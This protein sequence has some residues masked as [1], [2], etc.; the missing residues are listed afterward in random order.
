MKYRTDFVTNSSSSS[1][2]A[3]AVTTI[4]GILA[5]CNCTDEAEK[6]NNFMQSSVM[7]EDGQKLVAGGD[8]LYLYAQLCTT[9]DKDETI[10]LAEPTASIQYGVSEGGQWV[11]VSAMQIVGD[12]AAVEVSGITPDQDIGAAP[13]KIVIKA[14]CRYDKK[15][16]KAT[17]R[18][19][20][21]ADAKLEI[22]PDECNFLSKSEES[23]DLKIKIKNPGT[24]PWVLE[25]Q[26]DNWASQICSW[27]LKD[28][29]ENGD[30][31]TLTVSEQDMEEVSGRGTDYYTK[32]KIT[33]TARNGDKE[34]SDYCVVFMWR[35][36]LFL[37]VAT[38]PDLDRETGEIIIKA[39]AT[40]EGQMESSI[41]DLKFLRWDGEQ[42]KAVC[43]ANIFADEETFSFSDPDPRDEGAEAIFETVNSAVSFQGVRPS[44]MP[45]GKFQIGLDKI[46][47]GKRGERFRFTLDAT[48]DNGLDYFTVTI[49]FAIVPAFLAEG[50]A[51][52]QQEYDYCKKIITKFLP[53]KY[54]DFKLNEL[55][56]CKHYMGAADLKQYRHEVWDICQNILMKEKL[57]Y[58]AEAAWYDSALYYAE[59]VQWLN[60]RAFNVVLG[61]LTGPIGSIVINQCKE[62]MQDL[63]AKY[64]ES[65]ATDT[66]MSI[67]YDL[68]YNRFASV[69]GGTVDAKYFSNPEL[70]KKW[71]A[72][73]FMYKWAF[74]WA[75][76]YDGSDRKG[77]LEGLKSACWDLTAAGLEEKMKPFIGE[78]AGKSGFNQNLSIDEYVTQTVASL[79]PYLAKI[80]G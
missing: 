74:H 63:I 50:S 6:D 48:I 41:F 12:W 59:W 39:D 9:D 10:I 31:A 8:P 20:Y 73:F 77:C 14:S 34:T 72:M 54:R 53:A 67:V 40:A 22:K 4:A 36:G 44:N 66:W 15:Q 32:G 7:P 5:S 70:S 26:A 46:V 35:E 24:E 13:E 3:A 57:D 38:S 61:T 76:D 27:E 60:D 2:A 30:E 17:F 25:D 58:E 51:A 18:L 80:T 55:E 16:Y 75:F 37:D 19:P 43:D 33:L 68:L 28:I 1:F 79:T 56:N 11:R 23:V 65:K 52:W 29:S 42:H 21:E 71:V 69:F 47:P 64:V 49:P 78:M 45:S 62:M